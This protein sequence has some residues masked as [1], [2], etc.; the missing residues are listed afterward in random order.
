MVKT[1]AIPA[2]LTSAAATSTSQLHTIQ[3]V[4][5]HPT[6]HY[7]IAQARVADLHHQAQRDA[8]ARAARQARAAQRHRGTRPMLQLTTTVPRRVLT[9]LRARTT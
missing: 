1:A 4:T 7:Q 2:P 5:M 8:L 9:A 3:E 6:I